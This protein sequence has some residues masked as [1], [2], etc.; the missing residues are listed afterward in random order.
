[1]RPIYYGSFRLY[2]A[3]ATIL[4]RAIALFIQ[5]EGICRAGR[6]AAFEASRPVDRGRDLTGQLVDPRFDVVDRIAVDPAQE[7]IPGARSRG[8]ASRRTA[9]N[10]SVASPRSGPVNTP[11]RPGRVAGRCRCDG[12]GAAQLVERH[13]FGLHHLAARDA[14]RGKRHLRVDHAERRPDHVAAAVDLGDDAVGAVRR[15]GG[16]RQAGPP[17]GG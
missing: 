4:F 14:D 2:R 12:R 16:D 17:V 3:E 11:R 6:S 1:M 10:C 13:R 8:D 15:V 9:R 7:P 5:T